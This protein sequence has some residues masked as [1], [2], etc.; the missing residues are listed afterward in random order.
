MNKKPQVIKLY[1][2]WG[3][4]NTRTEE[5]RTNF[6]NTRSVQGGQIGNC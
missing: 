2:N 3:I 6:S 1:V 4:C 5:F